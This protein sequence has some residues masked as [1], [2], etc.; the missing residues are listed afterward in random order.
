MATEIRILGE[1]HLG[2]FE[3]W[4]VF[5]LTSG[6]SG[7]TWGEPVPFTRCCRGRAFIRNLYIR[8][9]G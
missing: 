4:R 1:S 7:E 3:D 2:R 8:H 9:M 6:D 5:V